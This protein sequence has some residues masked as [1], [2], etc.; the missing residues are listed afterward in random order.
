M[1]Q[2]NPVPRVAAVHDI[3]GF[4][5]SSL[6]I[7][8]PILS[9]MGVQ[10]CPLPT[11]LLST[12]T[13]GFENYYF[14]DLSEDMRAIIAHWEHLEIEFDAVYSGFLGSVKQ[15]DLVIRMIE[16]LTGESSFALVDPVL[17]DDGKLYGPFGSDMVEGMR[18]LIK[19]ADI[20]TP[21]YTEASLLL[22]EPYT[23]HIE[24]SQ[25]KQW[26]Y[27]LADMG[28]SCVIVT[29]VPLTGSDNVSSVFAYNRLDNRLWKVEVAYV[30]AAY[31]GT[32]D[33][34]SSV[35]VG[36]LLQHDS[37]PMAID[38]AIQFVVQA[39]RATFGHR[40]P[41]REGVL[42]EKVL[43]SLRHSVQI[44]TYELVD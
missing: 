14:R 44:S 27:R 9:T 5:R 33:M 23:P 10:V 28:P 18:R 30:P 35:I 34:F 24:V 36:S 17:G 3:S 43:D 29:S 16:H 40:M 41:H 42:L 39:I 25:I 38:R 13:S 22:D 32:G 19:S 12:Q 20:I 6:N 11:A 8:S 7:V 31:P 15:I 1:L 4:G 21:N 37:L 2:S 26:L